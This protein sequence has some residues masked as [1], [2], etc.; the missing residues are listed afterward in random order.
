M[1]IRHATAAVCE[2]TVNVR[3]RKTGSQ[4]ICFKQHFVNLMVRG[5]KKLVMVN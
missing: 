3:M 4:R 2:K 5:G 1:G